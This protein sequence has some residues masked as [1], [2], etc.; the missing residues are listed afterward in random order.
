MNASKLKVNSCRQLIWGGLL[1]A[2]LPNTAT[3][4]HLRLGVVMWHSKLL[5][6]DT[7]R[8][9]QHKMDIILNRMFIPSL[10]A[11]EMYIGAKN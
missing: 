9:A 10:G 4:I 8:T 6:A 7:N 3:V 11:A 5:V 2:R 1:T